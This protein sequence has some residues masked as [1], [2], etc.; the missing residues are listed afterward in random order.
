MKLDMA[1]FT[2]ATM[3]PAIQQHSVEYE[4]G[5]FAKFLETNPN[6]LD[7]TERWLRQ[8]QADVSSQREENERHSEETKR[9]ASSSLPETPDTEDAPMS[10]LSSSTPNSSA[11]LT[12]AYWNLLD[13]SNDDLKSEDF[14]E[15]LTVDRDRISQM[16][17][18]CRQLV[19]V[20]SVIVLTCSAAGRG[21]ADLREFKEKL[22][23]KLEAVLADCDSS[24]Q[25]TERLA[26]VAELIP[27][28]VSQVLQQVDLPDW[29]ATQ[30]ETFK[31]Q[32][33]QLA[34]KDQPVRKL[35]N[36]RVK[37]FVINVISTPSASPIKIPPGLSIVQKELARLTGAFL[38]VVSHNRSVFAP[39]YDSLLEK[40]LNPTT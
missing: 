18:E 26:S 24:E 36:N 39:Y 29:E 21:V 25:F 38:H 23:E 5:R 4:R 33:I 2:I 9:H 10:H 37:A 13:V 22:K 40:I 17:R 28:E 16:R 6:G 11:I 12:A 8:A 1:N 30:K 32:I 35:I 31:K 14:P 27:G 7:A 15:T 34:E 20:A 3:R 19:G